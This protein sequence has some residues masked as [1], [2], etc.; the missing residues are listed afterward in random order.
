[1]CFISVHIKSTTSLEPSLLQREG[2]R[3]LLVSSQYCVSKSHWSFRPLSVVQVGSSCVLKDSL[4]FLLLLYVFKKCICFMLGNKNLYFGLW[5]IVWFGKSFSEVKGF[6]L[7]RLWGERG[8]VVGAGWF[9]YSDFR[10]ESVPG[11]GRVS[12]L[13]MQRLTPGW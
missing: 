5:S 1:M 2:R 4:V 9:V 12:A 3:A 10:A 8:H 7:K 13:F 6:C 11:L